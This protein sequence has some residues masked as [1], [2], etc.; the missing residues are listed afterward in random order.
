MPADEPLSIR[1]Y[2]PG[3]EVAILD[4]FRRS[5]HAERSV[6]HFAWKYRRNPC[7]NEHISLAW[8]AGKLAAQYAAYPVRVWRDGSSDTAHHIGDIMSDRSVR[9]IGRG[10]TSIFAQTAEHFYQTFCRGYVAFNYG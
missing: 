5:F 3:D 4:L 2:S 1:P 8:L 7:G 6:E 9:H 10:E